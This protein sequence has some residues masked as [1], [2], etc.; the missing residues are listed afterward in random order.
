M[1]TIDELQASLDGISLEDLPDD[2]ASGLRSMVDGIQREIAAQRSSV[3]RASPSLES[4]KY[5]ILM[6]RIA[7]DSARLN[8]KISDKVAE[9]CKRLKQDADNKQLNEDVSLLEKMIFDSRPFERDLLEQA[10][11][12]IHKMPDDFELS[13]DSTSGFRM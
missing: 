7:V 3:P 2:L 9:L 13:D 12:A 6:L 1:I 11:L 8:K 5:A 10:A 4:V